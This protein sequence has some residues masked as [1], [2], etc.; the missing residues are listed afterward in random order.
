MPPTPIVREVHITVNETA[1]NPYYTNTTSLSKYITAY[2]TTVSGFTG[3]PTSGLYPLTVAFTLT[4]MNNNAS[5]VN[6]SFGDGTFFNTTTLTAFNTTHQYTAGGTYTVNETAGNPYNTSITSLSNYIT[7][8]NQTVS[9]FTGTPT[10]GLFPLDVQF[11]L[12][13]MDNYPILYIGNLSSTTSGSETAGRLYVNNYTT[14]VPLNTINISTYGTVSGNVMVSIYSDNNGYPGTLLFT[15]VANTGTTANSWDPVI[16]P[17]TYLAPG[18]YW[19]AFDCSASTGVVR[20]VTAPASTIQ[21]Y[22]TLAYGTA[23]PTNPATGSWTTQ[24][25]RAGKINF[26][27]VS[28]QSS[29]TGIWVNWSFGDGTFFNTTTLTAFNASH[30]YGSGGTYTVNETAANPYYTNTTSLSKYITAYNT[31]VSGFTSN[32]TSGISPL[33]VQFNLTAMNNNASYVNWS[34][35][36]GTVTNATTL[37]A[38]NASHLYNSAGFY[39]VNET[40]V[41]PYNSSI[42]VLSNYISVYSKTVSGFTGT[43]TS[44]LFPL[45]VQFNRTIPKDNATMWNWSADGNVTWFNTTSADLGNYTRTF[46]TRRNVQYLVRRPEPLLPEHHGPLKLHRGL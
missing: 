18:N 5:Y 43:P 1:A 32:V 40:A 2:N 31:T 38:F 36:D 23:F 13:P 20:Y 44:G 10:S 45:A 28:T 27:G 37:A 24:T 7:V 39:T 30:T 14:T 25:G 11:N 34:F 19:L 12:T 41:N 9:G 17:T 35:G 3:T 46:S 8:Y 42:S 33:G 22:Q 21:F 15:A 29:P 16:I 4:A 26:T 6:W